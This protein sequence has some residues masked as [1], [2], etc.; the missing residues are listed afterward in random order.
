MSITACSL[1]A[2]A[3]MGLQRC[4]TGGGKDMR[5]EM[6][7]TKSGRKNL[8][9]FSHPGAKLA[10]ARADIPSHTSDAAADDISLLSPPQTLPHPCSLPIPHAG[11]NT[12]KVS[13]SRLQR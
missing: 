3:V 5:A 6:P 11:K 12:P 2:H 7:G 10:G 4:R 9:F 8:I 1:Q 13:Q